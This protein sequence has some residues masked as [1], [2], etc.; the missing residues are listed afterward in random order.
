MVWYFYDGVEGRGE[1]WRAWNVDGENV[2][3]MILSEGQSACVI[4]RIV[5]ET[6]VDSGLDLRTMYLWTMLYKDN[7]L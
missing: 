6:L 7:T 3:V 2:W 4:H 5:S 1:E